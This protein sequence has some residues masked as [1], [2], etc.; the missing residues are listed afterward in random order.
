MGAKLGLTAVFRPLACLAPLSFLMEAVNFP[1]PYHGQLF[2]TPQGL[3]R[4]EPLSKPA[5][6]DPDG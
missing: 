5:K 6:F 4:K 3:P 1:Q 2:L